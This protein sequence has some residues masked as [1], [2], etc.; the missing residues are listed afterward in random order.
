M[1]DPPVGWHQA[2]AG[3][4]FIMD[5]SEV[6]GELDAIGVKPQSIVSLTDGTYLGLH[7]L[8]VTLADA[9]HFDSRDHTREDGGRLRCTSFYVD[10]LDATAFA[11]VTEY[12]A[13]AALDA[14]HVARMAC[15]CDRLTPVLQRVLD[16]APRPKVARDVQLVRLLRRFATP[17]WAQA[18]EI[19]RAFPDP[20]K[21]GAAY[22]GYMALSDLVRLIWV[23]EWAHI[24]LGHVDIVAAMG[25][26]KLDEHSPLRDASTGS[27]DGMP[28]PHVLQAFELQADQFAVS[29]ATQQILQGYDPAGAMAGPEVDLIHRICVLAAACA[30]FAVDA[31]LK[32]GRRDVNTATH[33]SAALRYMS[34]L[35]QIES[36]CVQVNPGL[37]YARLATY[38]MIGDLA[39][40]SEDFY[41]LLAITPMIVKTP[42]Y[43]S[44]VRVADYLF[45]NVGR[46]MDAIR[47][48]YVYLPRR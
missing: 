16:R 18:N 47:H 5:A 39:D 28:W 2:G 3:F 36:V 14:G 17:N 21:Q 46:R 34:M 48:R 19:A 29:F 4:R 22:G 40:L 31:E 30:V 12:G 7:L 33:P 8:P 43:K 13:V 1:I 45:E 27:I 6:P 11:G 32:E 26:P 10:R 15:I 44:M 23:H 25:Q 37:S 35:Q 42:S 38:N 41:G 20:L 24:L 9:E